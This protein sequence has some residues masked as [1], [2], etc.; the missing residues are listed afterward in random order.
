MCRYVRVIELLGD[1]PVHLVHEASHCA[2]DGVR[3]SLVGLQR[4]D[5][6]TFIRPDATAPTGTGQ[7]AGS[8]QCGVGE[9]LNA[10]RVSR[11]VSEEH[12]RSENP[13][14]WQPVLSTGAGGLFDG[15]EHALEVRP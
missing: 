11:R 1:S 10:S 5:A 14:Q 2:V 3:P 8:S 7:H 4:C 9:D 13:D 12:P 15:S 6:K